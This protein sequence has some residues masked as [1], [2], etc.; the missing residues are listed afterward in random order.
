MR[1]VFK[2]LRANKNTGARSVG[3]ILVV[4]I[5]FEKIFL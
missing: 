5:N 3:V 2:S 1:V 4:I